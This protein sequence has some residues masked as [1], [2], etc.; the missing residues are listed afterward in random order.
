MSAGSLPHG[1]SYLGLNGLGEFL[2]VLPRLTQHVIFVIGRRETHGIGFTV[3]GAFAHHQMKLARIGR[4][5]PRHA[6]RH[7]IR[8]GPSVGGLQGI[9]IKRGHAP[10]SQDKHPSIFAFPR[11]FGHPESPTQKRR[12]IA[13]AHPA[14]G[15]APARG[16]RGPI[17]GGIHERFSPLR[18]R[19]TIFSGRFRPIDDEKSGL[20][21]GLRAIP[22]F[23]VVI[24]LGC[25]MRGCPRLD[26]VKELRESMIKTRRRRKR[27]L[28]NRANS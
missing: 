22:E 2:T 14:D 17:P 6:Q 19:W 25:A 24:F 20:D 23:R 12:M 28:T 16:G 4:T 15:R 11:V 1:K 7:H 26:I 8:P 27:R 18:G 9:G 13:S 3:F 5:R 10:R 21:L